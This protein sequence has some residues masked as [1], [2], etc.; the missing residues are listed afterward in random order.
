VPP[1][2]WDLRERFAAGLW[3]SCLTNLDTLCH[4]VSISYIHGLWLD[5][6]PHSPPEKLALRKRRQSLVFQRASFS[7]KHRVVLL[8]ELFQQLITNLQVSAKSDGQNG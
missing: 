4:I 1:R 7:R 2:G 8:I 6:A 3:Q 5:Y